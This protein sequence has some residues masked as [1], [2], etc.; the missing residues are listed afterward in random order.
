MNLFAETAQ[1]PS[2]AV[3]PYVGE[4]STLPIPKL[5]PEDLQD[6]ILAAI[7]DGLTIILEEELAT[8]LA[9]ES[10]IAESV[11]IAD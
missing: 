9:A 3:I 2:S 1:V 7:E 6:N 11:A 10:N 4:T 8:E 5:R